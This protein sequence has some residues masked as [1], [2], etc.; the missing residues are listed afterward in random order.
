MIPQSGD[1][2]IEIAQ[3]PVDTVSA[4]ETISRQLQERIAIKKYVRSA[5]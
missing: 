3:V 1:G 4:T 2:S 5:N